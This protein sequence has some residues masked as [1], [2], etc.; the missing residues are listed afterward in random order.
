MTNKNTRRAFL[1][2]LMALILC[3]SSLL[4]TTYAWFTDSVTSSNNIIKSGNLDVELYYQAEGQTGWTKV[5][6]T[7]NIFKKDT[8]WEPGHTEVVKLK[9]VNE[10]S[11][12]LK[13]QL[14]VNVASEVG[15][16]NVNNVEFKL[17]D[18]IKFGIVDGAGTYTRDQAIA[19][20]EANRATAL[21]TAYNSTITALD[22][23][24]DTDS[25]E[26][27]VTMVV[28]MPTTVGNEANFK[29]DAAVPTINLG[30]NLYATQM[31][32][33]S[34]SFNDQ[35]DK[36][37]QVPNVSAPVSVPAEDVV[38]PVIINV[39]NMQLEVPAEVINNLPA[40]VTSMRL[41]FSEPVVE[42]NEIRFD[43]ICLVDQNGTKIEF[44][45]NTEEIAVTLPAQTAFAPGTT[46]EIYH[47]GEKMDI[48]SVADDGTISYSATHFSKVDVTLPKNAY[49][50]ANYDEFYTE[51]YY[52]GTVI[53]TADIALSNFLVS[54]GKTDIYLNGKNITG[55]TNFFF[56]APIEDALLSINGEGTVTTS[57]GY[58]SMVTKGGTF[59][60][61]GGTFNLGNTNEKAH[62]YTQNSGKTIING[63]TFISNDANTPILYCINGFIEINGGFF[64]N[65]AN[66]EQ[67]LLSM[68]N[69]INYVNNQKI[70]LSGGTFVNWNPMDSAFAQAWTNPDV[71]AL[72]VLADGYQMISETQANGDVWYSVVPVQ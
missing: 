42:D 16:V 2:S 14:G 25:D 8:L 6:D 43:Y 29:K 20:A 7:T 34:D 39:K 15:S 35:Y 12:A 41:I 51:V 33:E 26:K 17:S 59:V 46:V 60:V 32:A 13:Y 49:Y 23:K 54:P 36:D 64:Q 58:V 63:G 66:S 47:D 37:A 4:G 18:F 62:F 10:G 65:T 30:I 28:Y 9:V 55:Q 52:G 67:A 71:P 5:T 56:Y 22:A 38:A 45:G 3:V 69:N 72:I 70:T 11:L 44:E 21:K 31:T 19:A 68:G 50:V 24:N 53:P 1:A 48:V 27:I 40:E 61:N 57:T